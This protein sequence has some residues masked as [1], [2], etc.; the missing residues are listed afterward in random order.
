MV[1]TPHQEGT[2]VAIVVVPGASRDEIVGPH[3]DALKVRVTAAPERGK[4][5]D[6]VIHLLE[7]RLPGCRATL[8]SGTRSRR[9]QVLLEGIAPAAAQEA[10]APEG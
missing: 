2:I 7:R 10:L 6:A 8:L 3:G 9:K 4:A 1:F 5:N